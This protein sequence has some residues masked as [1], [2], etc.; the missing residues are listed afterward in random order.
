MGLAALNW[1]SGI[2]ALVAALAALVLALL[3]V[4]GLLR[5]ARARI[6]GVTGDVFGLLVETIEIL[7]LLTLTVEL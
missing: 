1:L 3:A 7:I 4:F 2:Q 6:G 5:F